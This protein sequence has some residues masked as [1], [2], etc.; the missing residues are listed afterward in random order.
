[1]LQGQQQFII[2]PLVQANGRFIQN[3]QHTH[4][5]RADLGSQS[6]PLAFAAGQ[7][8]CRPGQRQITQ[9][10]ILQ[11]LESAAD[12]PQ[13]LLC[14]QGH[15]AL[16]MQF[17][18]KGQRLADAHA[19]EI[20]NADAA[21]GHRPGNI[22]KPVA[23]TMG[24][25]CAGHAF[26]Q[27]LPGRV[28]LSVPIAAGNVVEDALKGLLQHAHTI[29]A[30]IGHAQ[31]F[32]AGSV[33]DHLH[34]LRRQGLHRRGQGETIFLCQGFKIHAENGIR[35]GT[36][37]TAGLDR[38]VKNRLILIRD[39]QVCI[40]HQPEAQAGT[41]RASAAGIVEGEHSGLQIRHADAAI[42]AGIILRKAQLFPGIRQLHRHQTAGMGTG[43]FD[44]VGQ[45]A[46]QTLLQHQAIHHQ[47]D[48]VLLILFQS[49]LLCQI[50]Q[51]AIH[52][53]TG[54]TLLAGIVKHLLMFALFAPNHRR[55]HD[56]PGADAQGLHPIHDLV[57]GLTGDL[58]ATLG[59]MG[60]THSGP[61]KTQ[62][63]VNF[64]YRTHRGTGIAGCGLLVDGNCRRKAIDAVHIGLVHLAQELPGI[65]AE[66]LHIPALAFGK[67]SIK[68]QAG[69]AGAG[70]TGKHH[71]L[72]PG[73]GH[74]HIF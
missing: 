35:P 56:K 40:R 27:F 62:I 28:G 24:A 1:M 9:A 36:L 3:I 49:D 60:H 33:E 15:I 70:Q 45:T 7:G 51:D 59:A 26:F 39:H 12:L 71:Q 55:Q 63:I 34:G 53:H 5:R 50:I 54:K 65:A 16:Q 41:F 44:G 52:T 43:S 10:H 69:F 13:D 30:I 37:P 17:I 47:L 29:A 67:N 64:R 72:I 25:G 2:V 20:H 66:A 57:N 23:A 42:L 38:T 74:I 8:A 14:D 32:L 58:L 4:Q 31:F 73:D 21:H 18:H 61:Q 22:R 6:D 48:G 68:C 46:A 19:A 11:E